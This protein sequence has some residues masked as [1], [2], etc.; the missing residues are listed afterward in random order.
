MRDG[1]VNPGTTGHEMITTGWIFR[2]ALR[3]H[4]EFR[5]KLR[6][7]GWSRLPPAPV[8]RYLPLR[9]LPAHLPP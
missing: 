7:H 1:W 2:Q 3:A 5:R 4:A 9:E 6:E 8:A